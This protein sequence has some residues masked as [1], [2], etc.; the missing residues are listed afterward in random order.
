MMADIFDTFTVSITEATAAFEQFAEVYMG[1][2]EPGPEL[3]VRYSRNDGSSF[4]IPQSR[5]R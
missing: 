2:F 5:Y 4:T 3:G 1:L